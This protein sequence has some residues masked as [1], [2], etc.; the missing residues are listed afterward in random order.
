MFRSDLAHVLAVLLFALGARGGDFARAD[1]ADSKSDKE[2]AYTAEIIKRADKIV[3]PLGI[4]DD[5]AKARVRDLIADQYRRLRDVHAAR[6]SRLEEVKGSHGG[7][8]SIAEAWTKV[9]RDAA[10]IQLSELHRRFVARLSVELTPEQVD[11]VKDG[12]TYGVVNVTFNRYL[13]LFPGLTEDQKREILANLIEARENAIDAGTSE[14]KH[15]IFGKY[16]GRIN[17]YLSAAGY[18][19]K[20]AEKDLAEKQKKTSQ[21]Q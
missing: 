8:K 13:Q 4:A 20:Q 14:E 11:Q 16:K 15:A 5:A 21:N 18:N 3:A 7:D 17:N 1:D 6:D 10:S 2:A 9:A 19:M 12:M